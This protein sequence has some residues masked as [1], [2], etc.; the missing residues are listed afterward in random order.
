MPTRSDSGWVPSEP[1]SFFFSR[2]VGARAPLI[3]AVRGREPRVAVIHL[4]SMPKSDMGCSQSR[5]TSAVPAGVLL[6]V[7][8]PLLDVSANADKKMVDKYGL[9]MNNAILAEEKH[10]P[11]YAELAAKEDVEYIAGGATQNSIRV[12]QW[13]L[14]A[15]GATS[16]I[17]CVG[18]DDYAKKLK[19]CAEGDGVKTYYL[20]VTCALY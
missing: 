16:Y 7:G 3:S 14:Q 12:A 8:N 5:D 10:M 4:D 6:G 9:K 1:R 11:I 18:D 20:T 13:M 17:G 15:Q 2:R 19:E